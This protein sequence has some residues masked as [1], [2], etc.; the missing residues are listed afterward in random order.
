MLLGSRVV[1]TAS[2]MRPN[3]H[4][5][6][7]RRPRE[8]AGDVHCNDWLGDVAVTLRRDWLRPLLPS[9]TPFDSFVTPYRSS[10]PWRTLLS[11]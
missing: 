1:V 10:G 3:G 8:R 4:G 5:I 6:Q 2:D 11:G 9:K 7:W